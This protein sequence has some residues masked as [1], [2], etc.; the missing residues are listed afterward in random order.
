MTLVA[1]DWE[2]RVMVAVFSL[3][4]SATSFAYFYR[5]RLIGPETLSLDVHPGFSGLLPLPRRL[6]LA[7]VAIGLVIS[8]LSVR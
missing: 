2:A 5:R 3:T 7:A 8:Q 4:L 6:F 1:R